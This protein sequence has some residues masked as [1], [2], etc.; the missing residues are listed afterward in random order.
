[1]FSFQIIVGSRRQSSWASCEFNTHRGRRCDSTGLNSTVES[2]RLRRCVLGII[3]C[4]YSLLLVI[5]VSVRLIV[6][7]W[8]YFLHL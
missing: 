1:M 4:R 7:R 8:A 2:R 3:H 6:W 5:I